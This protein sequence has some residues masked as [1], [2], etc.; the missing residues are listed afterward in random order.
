MTDFKLRKQVEIAEQ[1]VKVLKDVREKL[2]EAVGEAAKAFK[3]I[4]R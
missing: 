3:S 1:T 4:D 2:D